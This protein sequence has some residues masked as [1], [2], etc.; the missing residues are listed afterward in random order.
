M[1]VSEEMV[2]RAWIEW[3]GDELSTRETVAFVLRTA[4]A[5]VPEPSIDEEAEQRTGDLVKRL[6]SRVNA[7]EAKLQRVREWMR[8]DAIEASAYDRLHAILE[9]P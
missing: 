7:A 1:R 2:E 5:D 8:D 4:L 6:I 9:E 3:A